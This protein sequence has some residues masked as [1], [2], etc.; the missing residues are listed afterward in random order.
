M[1]RVLHAGFADSLGTKHFEQKITRGR[2]EPEPRPV[3]SLEGELQCCGR[4]ERHIQ[5]LMGPGIA[6]MRPAFHGLYRDALRPKVIRSLNRQG[7][8]HRRCLI[9]VLQRFIELAFM[10]GPRFGQPHTIG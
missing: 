4:S 10:N 1:C 8:Q 5:R 3:Q 6:Q 2:D 9:P 7:I